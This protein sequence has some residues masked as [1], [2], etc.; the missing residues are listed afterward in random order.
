MLIENYEGSLSHPSS[1]KSTG[2]ALVFLTLISLLMVWFKRILVNLIGDPSITSI[3][4]LDPRHF[5]GTTKGTGLF[6]TITINSSLNYLA[7]SGI[8]HTL[9]S[10]GASLCSIEVLSIET[11][12]IFFLKAGSPSITELRKEN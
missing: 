9:M 7:S 2:I 3:S 8:A 12:K 11:V 5:R 10:L 1:L 4:G 6:L